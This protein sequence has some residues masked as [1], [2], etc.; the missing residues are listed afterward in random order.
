MRG[1]VGISCGPP[2]TSISRSDPETTGM[3][4]RTTSARGTRQLDSVPA[5]RPAPAPVGCAGR[6]A[7]VIRH[8]PW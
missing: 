7:W 5:T 8:L 1:L 6:C 2:A 4:L 3:R